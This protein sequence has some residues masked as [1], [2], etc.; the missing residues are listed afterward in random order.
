MSET[1]KAV[2]TTERSCE[3]GIVMRVTY[4]SAYGFVEISAIVR[5]AVYNP[6][7]TQRVGDCE[8]GTDACMVILCG[9]F[10][11]TR[12]SHP[13]QFGL[14]QLNQGF[15]VNSVLVQLYCIIN[16]LFKFPRTHK[17]NFI[18]CFI[19]YQFYFNS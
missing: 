18:L 9:K 3:I 5:P 2:R 11:A 1:G 17:T 19:I 4:M 10:F 12:E 6:T 14:G 13:V 7:S 8:R 16:G 15:R